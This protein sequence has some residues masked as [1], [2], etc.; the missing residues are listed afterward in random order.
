MQVLTTFE[1]SMISAGTRV[2][3]T[4]SSYLETLSYLKTR[5]TIGALAGALIGVNVSS[6][7]LITYAFAGFSAGLAIGMFETWL[8]LD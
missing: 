7:S 5:C 4:D 1:T 2:V 6:A 8:W 3:D